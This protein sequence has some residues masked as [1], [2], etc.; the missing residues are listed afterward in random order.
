MYEKKE[1][2]RA[3]S[4]CDE[5]DKFLGLSH[6]KKNSKGVLATATMTKPAF[7]SN[8][9]LCLKVFEPLVKVLR[10]VD[11]DIK[12]LQI[13]LL[14]HIICYFRFIICESAMDLDLHL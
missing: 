4:Q 6:I 5:W 9:A 3:M 7:W 2:L 13:V 14:I 10:M 11:S 8:V 1:Q 12:P